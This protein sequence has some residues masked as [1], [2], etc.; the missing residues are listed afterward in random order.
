MTIY[1]YKLIGSG[2]IVADYVNGDRK[3]THKDLKH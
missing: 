2:Q 3:F 1:K